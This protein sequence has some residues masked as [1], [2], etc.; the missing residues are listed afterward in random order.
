MTINITHCELKLSK[1]V[2]SCLQVC[3]KLLGFPKVPPTMQLICLYADIL[4]INLST[5][6][7]APPVALHSEVRTKE[8]ICDSKEQRL[9]QW[10]GIFIIFISLK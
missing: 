7:H 4:M 5:H 9:S 6:H 3:R 8:Q 10:P 1:S 2:F